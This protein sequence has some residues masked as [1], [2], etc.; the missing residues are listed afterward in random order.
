MLLIMNEELSHSYC[1]LCQKK[2]K[3][4][5]YLAVGNK[6]LHNACIRCSKCSMGLSN[7][8]SCYEKMDEIYC[9]SCYFRYVHYGSFFF[10]TT[11]TA[12]WSSYVWMVDFYMQKKV[13]EFFFLWTPKGGLLLSL[14]KWNSFYARL[15]RVKKK[16]F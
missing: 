1:A 4:K 8:V 10:A 11:G 7:E 16:T 2:I 15:I 14:S 3:D 5:Y 9:R 12:T 13:L 6:K